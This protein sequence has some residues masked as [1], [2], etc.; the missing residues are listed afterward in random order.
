MQPKSLRLIDVTCSKSNVVCKMGIDKM[1]NFHLF[2]PG[3]IRS[4]SD[5]EIKHC[6]AAFI[7]CHLALGLIYDLLEFAH[8]KWKIFRSGTSTQFADFVEFDR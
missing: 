7:P 6:L 4:S 5:G 3:L 8:L 2:D 1:A